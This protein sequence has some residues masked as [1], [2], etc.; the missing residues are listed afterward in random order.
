MSVNLDTAFK[1]MA[2]SVRRDILDWLK[3]PDICFPDQKHGREL[4]VSAGQIDERAGLAQ[5]TVSAHLSILQRAGLIS[6]RK[7]G[8]CHSF[9]R[10]EKAIQAFVQL[11]SD[12]LL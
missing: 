3:N 9:K 5:S 2:H 1:A 4:G 8:A 11:M 7:S 12:K 6:C 10:D